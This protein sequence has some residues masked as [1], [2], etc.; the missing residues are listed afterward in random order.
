LVRTVHEEWE[1]AGHAGRPRLVCQV[2]VAVGDADIVSRARGAI[3]AYY[4]FTGRPGWGEPLS[5]PLRFADA[6]SVYREFGADE[7]VLD[8]YADDPRQVE[9]LA[10]IV[11]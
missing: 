1:V 7:L 8:C 4:A 5:N 10:A 3:E 6:V 9:A 11:R 2:N